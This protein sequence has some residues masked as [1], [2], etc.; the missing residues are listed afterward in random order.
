MEDEEL[1][2]TYEV[3]STEDDYE[4]Y[5]DDISFGDVAFITFLV[6]LGCAVFAFVI[7]TISKHLKHINLKIGNKIEIGVESKDKE[8][9]K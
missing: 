8:Y 1:E 6:I 2:E 9:K 5:E 4:D 7:R 3:V